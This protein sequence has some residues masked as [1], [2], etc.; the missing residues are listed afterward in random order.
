MTTVSKRTL[1]DE[2]GTIRPTRSDDGDVGWNPDDATV[3]A[4]ID[5]YYWFVEN[6]EADTDETG[7]DPAAPGSRPRSGPFID[8]NRH[9]SERIQ[10]PREYLDRRT[11]HPDDT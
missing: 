8:T 10:W 3:G 2:S 1:A 9:G 6:Y 11:R 5:T 4:P 7:H